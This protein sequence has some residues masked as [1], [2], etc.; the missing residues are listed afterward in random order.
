MSFVVLRQLL[1][2]RILAG[3]TACSTSITLAMLLNALL[4]ASSGWR[5]PSSVC[6]GTNNDTYNKEDRKHLPLE[7][8]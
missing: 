3:L 8:Y 5:T 6:R 2:V 7:R 1:L 4:D